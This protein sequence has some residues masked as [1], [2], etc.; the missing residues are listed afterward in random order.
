MII[1]TDILIGQS[2]K[3]IAA[4]IAKLIR[5]PREGIRTCFTAA[6]WLPE[7]KINYGSDTR[8]GR[9]IQAG[10]G[11]YENNNGLRRPYYAGRKTRLTQRGGIK[12]RKQ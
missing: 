3:V 6:V 10:N 11:I 12:S 4:L 7:R 8:N 5:E 2:G 9:N 1:L